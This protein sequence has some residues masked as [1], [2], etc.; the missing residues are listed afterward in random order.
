M[1]ITRENEYRRVL[2]EWFKSTTLINPYA[3]TLNIKE[4]KWKDIS[5]NFRYFMNRLNTL[6]LKK[7]Y[8]R[9][10]NRLKVIPIVEG[11]D[12]INPHY[13]C[14]L[15]NPYLNR[16]DE[17]VR[18]I[19]DSWKRT[20]LQNNRMDIKKMRD[21]GW[22]GYILKSRSKSNLLDSVDFNNLHL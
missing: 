5:Q 6:F 7:S 11:N 18:C 3:V 17:F 21:N 22:Y 15:D 4:I 2:M 19:E 1:L 20:P 10:G 12:V 16:D 14:V 13:H 9:Y 8:L